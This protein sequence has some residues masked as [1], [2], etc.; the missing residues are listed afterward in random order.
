PVGAAALQFS[1]RD[2]RIAS[3]ICGVSKAQRV[4]QT[5]DWAA[6]I[7]PEQAWA[8]LLALPFSVED[9]ESSRVYRPD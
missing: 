4:R 9:P 2:P 6:L 8:A 7:I 1:L 5:L 3:T